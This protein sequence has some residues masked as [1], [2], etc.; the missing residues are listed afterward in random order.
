MAALNAMTGRS[1]GRFALGTIL[2]VAVGFFTVVPI[3]LI[4]IA[5]FD[6][7]A[8]GD[9]WRWGFD[10]WGSLFTSPRSM[11]ALGYTLLLTLRVPVGLLL[12]FLV[13]WCLVRADIPAKGFIEF[14][15]WVAYFLPALPVAVGWILLLD[16]NYG[17][18]NLA[19]EKLPF[20]HGPLFS[21]QS[22]GGIIWVH[23]TL[24]TIPVMTI[25]LAPALR[26]L[27][28][29]LEL[30][31]N[32]CGSN[33]LQTLRRIVVPILAP[34]LVTAL[35]AGF[36]RGLEAFEVEQVLGIPANIYVYSTRIYDLIGH[37]PPQ[38][39]QAIALSTL[40]LV[41]LFVLTVFYQRFTSRRLFATLS[42]R[43]VSFTQVR[44]GRWRWLVS[45]ACIA[46]IGVGIFVPLVLLVLG[47]FMTLFGFFF[48]ANAFTAAHWLGVLNDETFLSSL[49]NSLIVGLSV[50]ALGTACYA[51]LGYVLVRTRLPGRTALAAFVWL[52]WAVPGV[53][54][55][56]SLLQLIL[57]VP[58]LS[59]IYGGLGALI[60]GLIVA[61]MPLGTQMLRTSFA[62]ISV[63]LEYASTTCGARWW[64]TFRRV[65]LPLATPMLV[66]IFLVT[67]MS[68]LRDMSTIVLLAG[69]HARPL[70]LLL[71]EYANAGRFE[72]A[73]VIGVILSAIALLITAIVR[74]SG[75]RSLAFS[76]G[77]AS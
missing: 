70:S 66:S 8:P 74:Q 61:N 64:T 63:E 24:T 77:S 18:V 4:A 32:V 26:Q 10:A 15:L 37:D 34:A 7:A 46:Y 52:P 76:E 51:L 6:S 42:G 3:L 22:I 45:G 58:F 54:L 23:L 13:A 12:G 30:S 21:A 36:I 68:A 41:I 72:E 38:F 40:M 20:V 35:L 25:L 11:S 17:L 28:A 69:A 67:L 9:P 56:M 65:M 43:G 39:Q 33:T 5:S 73:S 59:I 2:L 75:F 55:G 49:R 19:L 29:S 16:K 53:L 50:A 62:Q 60:L 48:I 27:D 47:S 14:S 44:L 71:L 57:D 31:A 1:A